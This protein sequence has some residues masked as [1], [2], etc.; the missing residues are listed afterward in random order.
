VDHGGFKPVFSITVP[1][2]QTRNFSA[3]WA[4][5]TALQATAKAK[6]AVLKVVIVVSFP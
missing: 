4:E 1:S 6:R 5:T 2:G 3:A